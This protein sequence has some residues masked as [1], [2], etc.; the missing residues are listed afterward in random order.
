MIDILSIRIL[1]EASIFAQTVVL[2]FVWIITMVAMMFTTWKR[3]Q[4]NSGIAFIYAVSL[5]LL[6]FLVNFVYFLNPRQFANDK[7]MFYGFKEATYGIVFFAIGN[8][9]L[10]P[11]F[12]NIFNLP[13]APR[14]SAEITIPEYQ[15]IFAK[16]Y[17]N[18]GI[19]S[20]FVLP[21]FLFEV[22]TAQALVSAAQQLLVVGVCLLCWIAW[23][24]NNKQQLRRWLLVSFCFPVL[25]VLVYGFLGFGTTMTMVILFFIVRF[26]KIKLKTVIIGLI[27]A[28]LGLSVYLSYMRDRGVIRGTVWRGEPFLE[29]IY[30]AKNVLLQ[31]EWFNPFNLK[32]LELIDSRLN[33]NT[34]VGAAIDNLDSGKVDFAHGETITDSFFALIPRVFWKE[35]FLVAGTS[36]IVSKYTGIIFAGEVSVGVGQVMEFYINFG[37]LG[38]VLGFL[39]LGILIALIDGRAGYYLS[40]GE[41]YKFVIWFL[42]GLA[43]VSGGASLAEITASAGANLVI[44]RLVTS[45]YGN[46]LYLFLITA[47]VFAVINRMIGGG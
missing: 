7:W 46:L 41:I 10:A 42:P 47:V 19:I 35:K 33:L 14:D 28:Y 20:F 24:E 31:P 23:K 45:K 11:F 43:I 22:P 17:F 39:I 1:D 27:L 13:I 18:I 34:F 29:R 5:A 3:R 2:I 4:T 36:N 32:H 38:V 16:K 30:A 6:H 9:I 21:F 26:F 25:T 15:K 37:R 40:K 44:A 12:L 8:L